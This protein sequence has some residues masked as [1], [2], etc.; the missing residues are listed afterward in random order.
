M[1]AIKIRSAIIAA[2]IAAAAIASAGSANAEPISITAFNAFHIQNHGSLP[3]TPNPTLCLFEEN[4]AVVNNCADPI[5]LA[6]DLPVTTSRDH[7]IA[8]RDY[9]EFAAGT[10]FS[11]TGYAYPGTGQGVQ[12]TSVTFTAASQLLYAKVANTGIY[13]NIEGIAVI[14]WNVPPGDGVALINYTP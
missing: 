8:V 12:G 14:C 2:T 6:F 4:G 9:W 11:C 5:N 1:L 3:N 7:T 10:S 13:P